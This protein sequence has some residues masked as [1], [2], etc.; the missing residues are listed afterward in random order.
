M[1]VR[2]GDRSADELGG[3]PC[4]RCGEGVFAPFVYWHGTEATG[5]VANLVFHPEC[6]MRFGR[7]EEREVA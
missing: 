7:I 5:E 2:P 6:A 4:F 1:I 3:V